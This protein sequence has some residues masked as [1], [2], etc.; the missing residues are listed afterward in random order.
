MPRKQFPQASFSVHPLTPSRWPDF[1][2]LFGANGAC[3]GCWCMLWR[4]K[5]ADFEKQK[6]AGNKAAM[7]QIVADG[8]I[9]G[10]LAYDQNE[11]IGWCALAPREDYPALARARVLK[12]IDQ[13]PVWSISCLFIHKSYRRQGVSVQLLKAAIEHVRKHGGQIIEGYPVEPQKNSIP[14]VFAWTGLAASFLKAGFHEAG[15]GSPTRPIMRF[16][17]HSKGRSRCK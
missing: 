12:P 8:L 15:R 2:K 10:L 1:V 4:L 9:P 7:Q 14:D 16:V 13:Q 3:G 17:I 11:P 6:G 5:R